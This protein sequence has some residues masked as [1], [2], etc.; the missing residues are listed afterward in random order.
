MQIIS[1]QHEMIR[2]F[3]FWKKEN[4]KR[5]W[6]SHQTTRLGDVNIRRERGRQFLIRQLHSEW[7]FEAQ[8]NTKR[9]QVSVVMT[10]ARLS[11]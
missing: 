3:V 9:G 10:T 8:L 5:V 2:F 7:N 11:N 4:S 6:H 1:V